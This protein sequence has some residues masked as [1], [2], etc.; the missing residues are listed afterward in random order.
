MLNQL[1]QDLVSMDTNCS[2]HE[3]MLE[4]VINSDVRDIFLDD[5]EFSALIVPENDP[6]IE[7][8]LASVPEFDETELTPKELKELEAMAESVE[9]IGFSDDD[10]KICTENAFDKIKTGFKLSGESF[11]VDMVGTIGYSRFSKKIMSAIKE[12]KN[13]D[14]LSVIDT[15]ATRTYYY[16]KTAKSA[17]IP[18]E[19]L[20]K[21]TQEFGKWYDN[22]FKKA[23]DARKKELKKK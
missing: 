14:Q 20:I 13:E 7:K 6:Q 4:S 15:I 11:I 9:E 19:S 12:A 21:Q 18:S 5:P 2:T 10:T 22:K 17:L 1:K 23:M 3:M 8:E 16:S